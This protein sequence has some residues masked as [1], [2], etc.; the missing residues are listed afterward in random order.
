M[1]K[2][3]YH[4]LIISVMFLSSCSQRDEF[5]N[6]SAD[7]SKSQKSSLENVVVVNNEG[8]EPD[9]ILQLRVA[10][11]PED[12]TF[13]NPHSELWKESLFR[14]ASDPIVVGYAIVTKISESISLFY[15]G[16]LC[17]N[18]IFTMQSYI[19]KTNQ[20]KAVIKIPHG[21]TLV[22]PPPSIMATYSPMG[23]VP[24]TTN[25]VGY[26]AVSVSTDNS[27]DTYYLV[28]E[29]REITHNSSGQQIAALDNP[30]YIPCSAYT[31][32]ALAFKYQYD[33]INWQ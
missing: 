12:Y 32:S 16:Y 27:Y 6:E 30:V 31:P 26:S 11:H 14:S 10:E 8:E 28:T 9:S 29:I 19:V 4:L 1:K 22:L 3:F 23:N 24:G 7:N 5:K 33:L 2:Y 18:R 21:A 13:C 20:Y 15:Q 17:D 25:T